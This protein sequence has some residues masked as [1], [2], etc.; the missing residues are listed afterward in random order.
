M[1]HCFVYYH[2][3]YFYSKFDVNDTK[4]SYVSGP[5]A[6]N[7]GTS[8][9]IVNTDAIAMDLA[10]IETNV[11]VVARDEINNTVQPGTSGTQWYRER[12]DEDL[13]GKYL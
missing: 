13:T 1:F 10:D 4:I 9:Q 11:E 5:G 2:F 3:Y 12:D 8:G 6:A 7:G